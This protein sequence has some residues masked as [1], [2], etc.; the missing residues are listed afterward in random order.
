M[1]GNAELMVDLKLISFEAG[2][3]AAGEGDPGRGGAA[4]AEEAPSARSGVAE[5]GRSTTG[6]GRSEA[7]A[8]A[9]GKS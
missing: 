1:P 2:R 7:G 3:Q 9:P 4:Q 6:G 5:E 8:D